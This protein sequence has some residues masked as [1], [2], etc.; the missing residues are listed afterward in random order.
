MNGNL[1]ELEREAMARLDAVETP[2]A[3][4]AWRR[5]YLGRHGAVTERLRGLGVLP[6]AERPEA[7]RRA[8][9]LKQRLELAAATREE[10]LR[11]APEAPALD[12]TLPGRQPA[13]GRLHPVRATM[14]RML[15]AFAQMG[16]QPFEGRDV[17]TD[18]YNFGLLNMPPYHPARDSH[19]T[20]YA[21]DP[22]VLLRTHTSPAQVRVMRQTGAPV[23]AVVPGACYRY[24]QPDASHNIMFYQLEGLAV[25]RHIRMGD[26]FG[27]ISGLARLLFG[28]DVRLRFR[29]H[30]FPFTEP[31]IETDLQCTVCGGA[32][33]RLCKESG[34]VEVIPGGMV[35]PT[36]LRNGGIDPAVHTG[37][38]FGAGVDRIAALWYRVP[39][40]RMLYEN[41]VR[42]L[43]Q[44]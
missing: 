5:G 42:F 24:D 34:W 27:A 28:E 44:F 9:A 8:N 31:S 17:E 33:C 19:D 2:D 20:F 11:S 7:G 18:E 13:A 26:L 39:D 1:E 14:R 22:G 37:F 25:G 10:A 41:D 12:V 40:I 38:A 32:G 30:Y 29:G 4:A 35:H 15:A 3:L 16:F 43:E 6:V 21:T 23:R 36:V